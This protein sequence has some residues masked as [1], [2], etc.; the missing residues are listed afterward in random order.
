MHLV[1]NLLEI[2]IVFFCRMNVD[3][4]VSSYHNAFVYGQSLHLLLH[5]A[6]RMCTSVIASWKSVVLNSLLTILSPPIPVVKYIN[7]A[8]RLESESGLPSFLLITLPF[9]PT[10]RFHIIFCGCHGS[11]S[12]LKNVSDLCCWAL[13]LCLQ[14]WKSIFPAATSITNI[15]TRTA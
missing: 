15:E 13:D 7:L 1:E 4:F 5:I 9:T 8:P 12:T 3:S 11:C 14:P 6:P 2:V 10:T